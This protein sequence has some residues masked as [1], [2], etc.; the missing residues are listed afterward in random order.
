VL[1]W[2]PTPLVA[3]LVLLAALALAGCS[4][5]RPL[6][7]EVGVSRETL[8]PGADAD[9]RVAFRYA[10]SRPATISLALERPDGQRLYLRQNEPRPP[11]TDYRYEFDGTAPAPDDPEARVVLP[12]GPYRLVLEATDAAGQRETRGADLRIAGAD[13]SPPR[14]EALGAFPSTISPNFDA[15]DDVARITYR[16]TKAARVS[17]FV[18]DAAGRRTPLGE[19]EELEPGEYAAVWAGTEGNRPVPDGAYQVVVRAADAAGNVAVA[20]VPVQ[21]QAGGTPEAKIVRAE[22]A[23]TRLMRGEL[24]RIEVTVRNTG[25]TVI[26]TQGPDPGYVYDSFDSYTSIANHQFYERA[27]LWRVGV[28]WSGAPSSAGTKY[29]Y[30]WGFGKDLQPGEEVTVVGYIRIQH[31]QTKMWFFAGLI[32]EG[33]AYHDDGVGGREVQVS[34]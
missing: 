28:D 3:T 26:R 17:L 11:G 14:I 4:T 31:E 24:L 32:Q 15:I 27:G 8:R 25:D 12:D 1:R 7:L 19:E 6:V 22:I 10:L 9:G 30:R 34:F 18:V 13:T 16:L 20:R 21:V 5:G 23:P 33:I 29:Q 2:R